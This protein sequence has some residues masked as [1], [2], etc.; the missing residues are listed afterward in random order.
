VRLALVG[1][2]VE[3]YRVLKENAPKDVEEWTRRM[4]TKLDAI[5]KRYGHG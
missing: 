4:L 1:K 2:I 3:R 5:R